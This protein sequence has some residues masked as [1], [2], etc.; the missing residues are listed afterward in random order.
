VNAVTEIAPL[1]GIVLA[2]TMLAVARATYYRTLRPR[3]P[4]SGAASV[5]PQKTRFCD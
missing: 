3:T 5:E 1:V 4:K 2:C